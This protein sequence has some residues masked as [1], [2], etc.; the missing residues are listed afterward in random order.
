[1]VSSCTG[2]TTSSLDSTAAG[3]SDATIIADRYRVLERIDRGG[4]AEIYAVRDLDEERTVALKVV[5]EPDAAARERLIAEFE[6]LAALQHRN[7][8][9]PHRLFVDR[10]RLC[11]TMELVEGR[12]LP[13]A[14]E[15]MRV[16]PAFLRSCVEQ[17]VSAIE[18]I[19]ERGWVHG[20]IA[21]DNVLVTPDDRLVVIDPCAPRRARQWSGTPAYMAPELFTGGAP[22]PASDWY[23]VGTLLHEC[24]GGAV[25]FPQRELARLVEAK[26]QR[27]IVPFDEGSPLADAVT[28]LLDPDPRA[29]PNGRALTTALGVARAASPWPAP[30]KGPLIGRRR[31]LGVLVRCLEHAVAERRLRVVSIVGA[32]GIGK[33]R[34]LDAFRS[35]VIDSA[36]AFS[37]GWRCTPAQTLPLRIIGGV[38]DE[39]V[40]RARDELPFSIERCYPR[41]ALQLRAVF[42]ST[43]A[44]FGGAPDARTRA[45]DD[46]ATL[47]LAGQSAADLLARVTEHVPIVLCL[48]DMQRSDADSCDAVLRLL[49]ALGECPVLCVLVR[50]TGDGEDPQ[51]KA[52]DDLLAACKRHLGDEQV[53][54]IDL[55]PLPREQLIAIAWEQL[56][57]WQGPA[58]VVETIGEAAR[59]NPGMCVWY[60]R[61]LHDDGAAET[62]LGRSDAALDQLVFERIWQRLS[63]DARASFR[64]LAVAREG[65][66][67]AVIAVLLGGQQRAAS[68]LAELEHFGFSMR[69]G[70]DATS[71]VSLWHDRIAEHGLARSTSEEILALHAELGDALRRCDAALVGRAAHHLRAAGEPRVAL[72]CY[73]RAAEHAQGEGAHHRACHFI[74][75]ALVLDG[76][77]DAQRQQLEIRLADSLARLGHLREAAELADRLCRAPGLEP[78]IA[79]R[80]RQRA[81]GAFG[82]IADTTRVKAMFDEALGVAHGSTARAAL[83]RLIALRLRIFARPPWKSPEPATPIV[84]AERELDLLWIAGSRLLHLEPI[85]AAYLMSRHI[86][87][88]FRSGSRRHQARA[89]AFEAVMLTSGGDK[90]LTRAS[91]LLAAAERRAEQCD[92]AGA[93]AAIHQGA[94]FMWGNVARYKEAIAEGWRCIEVLEH[95]ADVPTYEITHARMELGWRLLLIGE[96]REVL[97][98]ASGAL[99]DAVECEDPVLASAFH[100]QLANAHLAADRPAEGRRHLE[101][102]EQWC[103]AAFEVGQVGICMGRLSQWVYEQDFDAALAYLDEHRRR[104]EALRILGLPAVRT[105]YRYRVAVV[106][107]HASMRATG[108]R[109]VELRK[110]FDAI[111]RQLRRESFE[112]ALAH[113]RV[114]DASHHGWLGDRV[115]AMGHLREAVDRFAALGWDSL[116]ALAS[117][118]YRRLQ[119]TD[120]DPSAP[121]VL[122]RTGV[123]RP[124]RWESVAL[125]AL[126]LRDAR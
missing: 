2:V 3:I 64:W 30:A 49:L 114:L 45:A 110:R 116:A 10:E 121:R 55:D 84:D 61:A 24:L 95:A 6:T 82:A 118:T 117:D 102:A 105:M 29:R 18:A 66:P 12:A 33:S 126:E 81:I 56:Q 107:S 32:S 94:G 86:L 38:I 11:Y 5:A 112:V 23:A 67:R 28:R 78:A 72:E 51:R 89:L 31:E 40:A 120:P 4:A 93:R 27:T 113:A 42:P 73:A 85:V 52:T 75:A 34:L 103:P 68:A 83:A 109:A 8:V 60:A 20:D 119:G 14:G 87:L 65:L 108:T 36:A 79:E 74:R 97:A 88:A 48:D 17:L 101:A 57:S 92:D 98:L 39:L 96:Y 50:S 106:L 22:S 70:S 104:I 77:S 99:R 123:A 63:D 19:H 13:D 71:V 35:H 91:T 122:A 90:R 9:V 69:S 62:L 80:L 43:T 100:V 54:E 125:A 76:V 44:L 7:I 16:D 37:L 1:V 115:L 124:Q 47:D 58:S 26:Q 59:G 46:A 41:H 111:R 53:V 15:R 21:P 25:A